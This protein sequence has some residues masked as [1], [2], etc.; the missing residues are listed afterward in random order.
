LRNKKLTPLVGKSYNIFTPRNKVRILFQKIVGARD[1]WFEIFIFFCTLIQAITTTFDNPLQGPLDPVMERTL[2]AISNTTSI[3]FVLEFMIKSIVT[4]F[5][6]NG[7]GSYL[8]S[9]WNRFDFIFVILP[10]F[11]LLITAQYAR[12]IIK[13]SK[14]FRIVRSLRIIS[15]NEGLKNCVEGLVL[16]APGMIRIVIVATIY[17]IL[18]SIYFVTMLKGKFHSC[19]LPEEI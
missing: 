19:K 15:R 10:I 13:L 16:S 18:H 12:S 11:D 2:N 4:G 6:F 5:Y 17:F 7:P 9:G 8:K 1:S 14:I 3:I